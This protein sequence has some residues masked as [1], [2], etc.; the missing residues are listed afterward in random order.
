MSDP[1][2]STARQRDLGGQAGEN[3]DSW[4]TG[5]VGRGKKKKMI[6]AVFI[7]L[8]YFHYGMNSRPHIN[9]RFHLLNCL[10]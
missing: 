1:E 3:V 6:P 8:K 2:R 10:R 7:H 4:S 9:P 5:R